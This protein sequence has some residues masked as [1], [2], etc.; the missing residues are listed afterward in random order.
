MGTVHVALAGRTLGLFSGFN[1]GITTP[2]T[3]NRPFN[4]SEIQEDTV[5]SSALLNCPVL[6]EEEAMKASNPGW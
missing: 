3:E 2:T 4:T 6:V 1:S 5:T